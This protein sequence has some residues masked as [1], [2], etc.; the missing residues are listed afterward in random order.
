MSSAVE[1]V[2]G[3]VES[4]FV[5]LGLTSPVSRALFGIGVGTLFVF[6]VKPSGAFDGDGKPK[7]F[8]LFSPADAKAGTTTR[9]PWYFYP[10]GLGVL[11]GLFV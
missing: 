7:P 5:L 10:L 8:S 11:F 2:Y 9:F 3:P 1:S 6:L 4:F